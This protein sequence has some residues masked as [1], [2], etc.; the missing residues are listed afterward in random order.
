M[1]AN[2]NQY[3]QYLICAHNDQLNKSI[4]RFIIILLNIFENSIEHNHVWKLF[5]VGQG[6]H[7]YKGH[8]TFILCVWIARYE[9]V[10]SSMWVFP[11]IYPGRGNRI[12]I[13]AITFHQ[14]CHSGFSFANERGMP[15][16]KRTKS[17]RK[18]VP[19]SN[20]T[21][22]IKKTWYKMQKFVIRN[23]IFSYYYICRIITLN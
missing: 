5:Y 15:K 8:Y 20:E 21:H 6:G 12:L 17:T 19:L 22:D 2:S 13:I 10:K 18:S 16:H 9:D 1:N 14:I 23:S 11:R 3:L 4:P 7:T